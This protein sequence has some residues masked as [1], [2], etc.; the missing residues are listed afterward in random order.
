M[1]EFTTSLDVIEINV[2]LL[3]RILAKWPIKDL[4][5]RLLIK[6]GPTIRLTSYALLGEFH[7]QGDAKWIVIRVPLKG[8][9]DT[10]CG[11]PTPSWPIGRL[12]VG[13]P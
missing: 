1:M 9:N 3:H 6:V 7:D 8:H 12:R 5:R 4:K 10:P 11:W 13:H 2:K